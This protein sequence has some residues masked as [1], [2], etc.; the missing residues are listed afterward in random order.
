MQKKHRQ[1]PRDD[2]VPAYNFGSVQVQHST[3]D[4]PLVSFEIQ[5]SSIAMLLAGFLRGSLK[6]E[7]ELLQALCIGIICSVVGSLFQSSPEE[8]PF[9]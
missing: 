9:L 3:S 8:A 4:H 1:C 6:Q 5:M 2:N 7:Q